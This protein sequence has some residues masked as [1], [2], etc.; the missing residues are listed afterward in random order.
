MTKPEDLDECGN[1]Y[2]YSDMTINRWL[3]SRYA[4]KNAFS[5]DIFTLFLTTRRSTT[6]MITIDINMSGNEKNPPNAG[7]TTGPTKVAPTKYTVLDNVVA[8]GISDIQQANVGTSPAER[9]ANEIFNDNFNACLSMSDADITCYLKTF[10]E[11]TQA[12]GQVKLC[13]GAT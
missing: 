13:L 3:A 11:L 10:S 4:M 1:H 6:M 2:K 9:I 7:D 5:N 8:C 12:Q